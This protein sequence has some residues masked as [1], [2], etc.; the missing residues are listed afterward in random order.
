MHKRCRLSLALLLLL[1]QDAGGKNRHA[2]GRGAQAQFS[3]IGYM[4]LAP[5][6]VKLNMKSCRLATPMKV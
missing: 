1:A 2:R 6:G 3:G 4:T 5:D